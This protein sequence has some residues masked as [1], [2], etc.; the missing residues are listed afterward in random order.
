[1]F[2]PNKSAHDFSDAERF[3]ELRF[4]TSGH[5][6]RYAVNTLYRDIIEKMKDAEIDDYMLVCSLPI[7]NCLATG[8]LA[9]RF[10]RIN[11]LLW[12]D[13]SYIERTVNLDAL[14]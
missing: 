12:R 10:G 3:G 2:I 11:F 8:I 13:N 4:L 14:L 1:M 7:L 5:M 9:R 6:R